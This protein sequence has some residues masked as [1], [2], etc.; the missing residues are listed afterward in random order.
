[1][2][3]AMKKLILLIFGLAGLFVFASCED[4][5]GPMV[6]SN[7]EAPEIT[8]L[9]TGSSIVLNK[10]DEEMEMDVMSWSPASFGFSAAVEYTI[11]VDPQSA[12][13]D[14]PTELA[15]VTDTSY[16]PVI[17]VFNERLLTA[18]L[19]GG[20]ENTVYVRV[21]AHVSDDVSPAY[22][23]PVE[24]TVTPFLDSFPPIFMIGEAVGG[25]DPSLAVIIPSEE[26]NVYTNLA[27][28]ES[29]AAFRFFGQ[30]DWGP[31]SYNY[32]YFADNGGDIDSRLANAQ[33]GDSN[34]Q[35][36]GTT[37]WYRV[38]VNLET[39]SVQ[40]EEAEEPIMYMTGLAVGAWDQPGTGESVK[41][42]FVQDGVYEATTEF[43]NAGDANF[44]FFGQADWGPDSFNYPYFADNNGEIDELLLDA[45]DGDNN[46]QFTGDDGS[47]FVRVD[48]NGYTVEME[49]Q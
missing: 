2:I 38:T 10:V 48:I 24:L 37:G 47:Y 21:S 4:T 35:F 40:L 25:W 3:N 26:P 15:T 19:N 33:D 14:T 13:F 31:D 1:M 18:G 44:R 9:S 36:T 5:T 28:F 42:T 30:Q 34:F 11:E 12:S 49:S 23:E 7:P 27:R 8:G 46:F 20:E 29:D 16:S 22:S 6:T 43:S 39:Y 17:G 41:M 45:G 32:P